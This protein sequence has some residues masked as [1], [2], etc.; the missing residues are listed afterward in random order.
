MAAGD[1]VSENLQLRLVVG[2]RLIGEQK[3]AGHHLA[4]GLLRVRAHDDA[5]LE[6]RVRPVVNDRTE[7]LAAGATRND[8]IDD[9]RSVAML[10]LLQ[11]VHA[12]DQELA[13]LARQRNE[14]LQ[15]ADGRTS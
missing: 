13:A 11:E 4:V 15:A 7:H 8:M 12:V 3:R 10:S 5:A 1:V 9:Q 2:F 14:A 6:Y